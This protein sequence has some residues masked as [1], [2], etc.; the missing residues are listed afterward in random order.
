MGF[1][2]N[3]HE[4]IDV[5]GGGELCLFKD[6][7]DQ[8]PRWRIFD[9][10]GG[11][12]EGEVDVPIVLDPFEFPPGTTILIIPPSEEVLDVLDETVDEDGEGG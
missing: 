1:P 11:N 10:G 7:H 6:G 8:T 3:L 5:E 9:R 12:M 2:I 4:A